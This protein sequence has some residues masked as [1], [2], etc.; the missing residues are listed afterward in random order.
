MELKTY[1]AQDRA[2]NLIPNATVTIYLTGTNTLA[3]GLKTATDAALSNP[4]TTGADGKIQFKAADGLYDMQ[5]SYSTQIGPRITIQC[6]DLVGQVAAAEQA[7]A[8]AEA[9]MDRTQ[10]I[11]DDAGEQST[12]VVLAQPDGASKV[13]KGKA[14]LSETTPKSIFSYLN[15]SDRATLLS[16]TGSK[17]D[18]D[19][20]LKA[21]IADGVM[22]LN[23]PR[24]KGRYIFGNDPATLP[25]G[26]Y[27]IG[28]GCFRPYN[29]LTDS[30]FDGCGVVV[31]VASGKTFPFYSNK[32]H[33]FRDIVFN[34]RDRTTYLL[35]STNSSEQFNGTRFEGCGIYNFAVGLGWSGYTGTLFA[36]RCSVSGNTDGV[37][38]LIDSN[39]IACVI[40]AN[41]RGVALTGGSNNNNFEA[42]RNEWNT[43]DNY[44]AYESVENTIVG[45]LCDRAGRG[46]VVAGKDGQWIVTGVDVRRCGA[47]QAVGNDYSANF[48]IIDNGKLQIG[49]VRTGKGAND[50]GDGGTTSPS[51]NVSILGSGGGTLLVSGSD[52]T[53]FVTSAINQKA[54]TVSKSITGCLG[55]NDDVN[56]GM[57]QVV[58]GRRIIG[59]LSSGSLSASVGATLSVTKT[60]ILQNIY[61]TYITRAILIECRIGSTAQS[62]YIK[63]PIG[64]R[65]E[66]NFYLDIIT[67][68][69]VA[70]SGRIGMSG[71]GVTVALSIS[72]TDGTITVLLTSVDGLARTVNVSLLP[73]M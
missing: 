60:N 56:V 71:T 2:G 9:A 21:A 5:I 40:N 45:E 26:F 42:C 14:P 30:A 24:V 31:E 6:L 11:I 3:T 39:L 49:N 4:F 58:N 73:S 68:G 52:M 29:P 37:R 1:F 18:C 46:G 66:S 36:S 35:Y 16:T 63:I 23:L 10:Q 43:T 27:L 13:Y 19:Y 17:V 38:N 28:E 12:L 34:G 32:R 70:N 64:V 61:D 47:N 44:Y 67:S 57:N 20:A 25:S 51:F 62:D 7:A 8:D 33:V 50:S 41:N 59:P 48:I 54:T 53:G 65:H 15:S 22:T 69:I 72:A 55:V